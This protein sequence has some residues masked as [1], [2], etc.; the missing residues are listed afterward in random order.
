MPS[1]DPTSD[2]TFVQTIEAQLGRR[3]TSDETDLALALKDDKSPEMIAR[4]LKA[5]V[6]ADPKKI[7]PEHK[8]T[9]AEE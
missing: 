2:T 8:D 1:D 9:A 4:E 6:I 3:L 7:R 5:A